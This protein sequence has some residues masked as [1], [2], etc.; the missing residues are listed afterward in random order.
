MSFLIASELQQSMLLKPFNR[1]GT[2]RA[3]KTLAKLFTPSMTLNDKPFAKRTSLRKR[4]EI[5]AGKIPFFLCVPSR[6]LR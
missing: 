6:P 5:K 4:V 3:L 1:I 2:Q